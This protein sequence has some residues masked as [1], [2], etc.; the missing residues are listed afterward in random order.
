[1]LPLANVRLPIFESVAAVKTPQPRVPVVDK[2]SSPKL[3]APDESVML[4]LA[5]VRL[6]IF[7]SEPN[8]TLPTVPENTSLVLVAS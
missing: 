6:P 1:M 8:T 7:E 3:M 2:F 5:N 4:P